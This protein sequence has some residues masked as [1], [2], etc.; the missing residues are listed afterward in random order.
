[1]NRYFVNALIMLCL[2]TSVL[3]QTIIRLGN[4]RVR[5]GAARMVLS[6][7]V[8]YIYAYGKDGGMFVSLKESSTWRYAIRFLTPMAR[9]AAIAVHE[10]GTTDPNPFLAAKEVVKTGS[11]SHDDDDIRVLYATSLSGSPTQAYVPRRYFLQPIGGPYPYFRAFLE[12]VGLGPSKP[13]ITNDKPYCVG[14]HHDGFK[15][16]FLTREELDRLYK[17]FDSGKSHYSNLS[18]YKA[19]SP[20][21]SGWLL[22]GL[23]LG[24]GVAFWGMRHVI[25]KKTHAGK[26]AAAEE[27]SEQILDRWAE[28]P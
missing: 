14:F 11:D 3:G 16:C 2:S 26:G 19:D 25:L 22:A 10:S 17:I 5:V 28:E 13:T 6:A 8:V 1:M 21:Q 15:V 18:A 23:L 20:R 12:L 7:Q 4:P 9:P 24:I 27:T